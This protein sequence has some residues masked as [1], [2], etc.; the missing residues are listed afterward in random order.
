MPSKISMTDN[1]CSICSRS[2]QA[3]RVAR[4]CCK[5]CSNRA[6]YLNNKEH[7]SQKNKAYRENPISLAKTKI[8][9][10][11]WSEENTEHSI[12][13]RAKNKAKFAKRKYQRYHAE[14]QYRLKVSLRDRLNHAIKNKQKSGSAVSDIGCTIDELKSYL[15]SKFQP[16][17]SWDNWSR[18]GWH[19][20]HV[21]P[22]S[23]FDLSDPE[24]LRKAC[25]YTNLQPL[26]AKQNLSKGDAHE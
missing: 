16:G 18:T 17:M 12:K 7:R 3:S 8:L 4:F 21:V 11:K 19:I 13:Y 24:Q 25:H 2:F 20:D 15:E 23:S 6:W 5:K 14:I 9:N 10:K 26:W 22:L 1:Q